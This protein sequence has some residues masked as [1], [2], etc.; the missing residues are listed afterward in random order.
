[1]QPNAPEQADPVTTPWPMLFAITIAFLRHSCSNYDVV[2][3]AAE[4]E[5][6]ELRDQLHRQITESAT[7]FYPWLRQDRDPRRLASNDAPIKFFDFI[8]KRLSELFSRR[9]QLVIN[10][11]RSTADERS[12]R[13]AELVTL[14]QEIAGLNAFFQ[15]PAN[16]PADQADARFFC[17]PHW[18]GLPSY[19]FAALDLA[20][21]Y[22]TSTGFRCGS[23]GKAV[24]RSKC[25]RPLGA[26]VRLMIWSCHCWTLLTNRRYGIGVN[27]E[28]WN[29][30]IEGGDRKETH[31]NEVHA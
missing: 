29:K 9:S 19:C 28:L 13:R 3:A 15:A 27:A 25:P 10:L 17:Y 21:S 5:S 12:A 24:Q 4:D 11:R 18:P 23:C 20:P 26:G 6:G 22:L 16:A 31:S 7:R 2:L 1:L 8:S 14:D 30:L